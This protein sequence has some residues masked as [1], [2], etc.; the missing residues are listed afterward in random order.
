MTNHHNPFPRLR[1]SRRENCQ[2]DMHPA[3]ASEN[4]CPWCRRQNY[5]P[6]SLYSQQR[7]RVTHVELPRLRSYPTEER[8]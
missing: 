6:Q 2:R 8:A 4:W 1:P 3:D 7:S 5:R